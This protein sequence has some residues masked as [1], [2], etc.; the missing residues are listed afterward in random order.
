MLT[1]V[2]R[3]GFFLIVCVRIWARIMFIV[4]PSRT[5]IRTLASKF[6]I[7]KC[8]P[9]NGL[10]NWAFAIFSIQFFPYYGPELFDQRVILK[11]GDSWLL[12]SKCSSLNPFSTQDRF[13]QF[14][15]LQLFNNSSILEQTDSSLSQHSKKLSFYLCDMHPLFHGWRLPVISELLDYVPRTRAEPT[16]H[17]NFSFKVKYWTD[18]EIS[19]WVPSWFWGT[20]DFHVF[21]IS[22][23]FEIFRDIDWNSINFLNLVKP[24]PLLKC[25]EMKESWLQPK[26]ALLQGTT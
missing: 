14:W 23:L 5:F 17:K 10:C 16:G 9:V 21:K 26:I 6:L 25:L 11:P 20:R 1:M 13:D 19:S 22:P 4:S 3:P 2:K 7:L 15:S 18:K 12:F 24:I 8:K